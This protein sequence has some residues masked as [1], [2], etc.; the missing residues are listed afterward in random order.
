[1]VNAF[2]LAA[3]RATA[4]LAEATGRVHD[5]VELRTRYAQ[6]LVAFGSTFYDEQRGVYTDGEGCAHAS[7]H[8]NAFPLAF[9]LVPAQHR[10][11]VADFVESRGMAC[12]VYGA[13]YLLD[14]LFAAGRGGAAVKLLRD[15]GPRSWANMLAVG[16][17]MTLE[18]WD[19]RFKGNLTWNHA[20]GAVPANAVA[21]W[22]LGVQPAA[23]GYAKVVVRPHLGGLEWAR[24][25]VPTP[26][27]PVTVDV[28]RRSGRYEVTAPDGVEVVKRPVE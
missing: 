17:T 21:R 25:K 16:S 27:G 19:A 24:G 15:R 14:G 28:D 4:E 2:Y 13:Q 5:A 23:P 8:A 9:G 1:V 22:V 3:L 6:G 18:A 12:S 26:R 10:D 11:S 7:L 20:W